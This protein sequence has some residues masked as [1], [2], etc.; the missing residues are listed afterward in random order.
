MS[1]S[2]E[3][4]PQ[5][6]DGPAAGTA[7]LLCGMVQDHLSQAL[8]D[9]LGRLDRLVADG[10]DVP[11]PRLHA[12]LSARLRVER[13]SLDR[14]YRREIARLFSPPSAAGGRGDRELVRYGRPA[15]EARVEQ[16]AIDALAQRLR[17][18]HDQPLVRLEQRLRVRA[19]RGQMPNLAAAFA[20]AT[21]VDTLRVA[22]EA[23]D[24]G[25]SQ[26]LALY[27]LLEPVLGTALERILTQALDTLDNPLPTTAA[28]TTDAMMVTAA[29]A[30]HSVD[31]A[32]LTALRHEQARGLQD[33][34]AQ[35]AA[36][37]LAALHRAPAPAGDPRPI[38][39]RLAL[40]GQLIAT[41]L[42]PLAASARAAF[43]PL[44][45]TLTKIVLADGALLYWP[46]HPVRQLLRQACECHDERQRRQ[47]CARIDQMALSAR[48]VQSTLPQIAPLTATQV[49]DCLDG[50]RLHSGL[51]EDRGL[52]DARRDVAET[53]AQAT[54]QHTLPQGLRLFLRAGW[55]PLLTQ[56]LLRHGRPSAPWQ[57][58]LNRLDQLL[59]AI[60]SDATR[61]REFE[62]L[63]ATISAELLEAGLRGDR[64]DR[65]QQALREAFYE[66]RT[67]TTAIGE[68]TPTAAPQG[69]ARL[70][71]SGVIELPES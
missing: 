3:K 45:F 51:G 11:G 13:N 1:N 15:A 69:A 34:D 39:Q 62:S 44:R 57:D 12:E 28:G 36:V 42:E 52:V 47:L 8:G 64:C 7:G 23:Q 58:G 43:E 37:L 27:A 65:L 26:R 61:V 30:E 53:L 40:L 49:T 56:R 20:P 38:A 32:M 10:R 35:L 5:G 60:S 50:L 63:L 24:I 68:A 19:L 66:R 6:P 9:L 21:L 55:G 17:R 22:L 70:P 59:D 4:Q 18:A 71:G 25:G 14:R 46:A 67:D 31:E 54:L 33:A 2:I 16:L 29:D 41:S 48:F